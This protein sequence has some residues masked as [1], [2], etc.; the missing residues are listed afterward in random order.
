MNKRIGCMLVVTLFATLALARIS[1]AQ[2]CSF[3]VSGTT[4]TLKGDCITTTSIIIP[5]GFTL[6]G[7]GHTITAVDP[8]NDHFR[9]GVIQNGGATANVTN[10]KITTSGLAEVCDAGPDRL[11]GILFD[12]AS[13]YITGNLVT[14]INENQGALLSGC[15][16]GNGIE[17]RNFGSSPTTIR[18]RIDGNT[19]TAYQKTGIVANGNTDATITDNTVTGDGPQG[20]IAQNGIQVGFGATASVKHNQVSGNAYTGQDVGGGIIVVAGPFYGSDFSVGDQIMDNTVTGNDIGIW[21]T[22]I[23]SDFSPPATATNLKVVN[24]IISN[25][26]LTN[27]LVYQAGVADQGNNDKI[28]S[29]TISGAG[30]DP[31]NPCGCTFAIDADPSFTNRPKVHANK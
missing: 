10:V 26:A 16:E 7:A 14:N 27:G 28:I 9:G 1:N 11:R 21:L 23:N 2:T 25:S 13:G 29:N 24:N 17:A 18:V 3:K 20:Y 31:N 30:Y 12:G 5:N 6:D 8:V 22:Q 4:Q 19:V 15:Q